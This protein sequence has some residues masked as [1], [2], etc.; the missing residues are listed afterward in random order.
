MM[1]SPV[2]D[3]PHPDSPTTPTHSPSPTSKETPSTATTAPVRV[4]NSVRRLSTWR[5]GGIGMTVPRWP[6]G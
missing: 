4:R 5:T 1:E 3:L 6:A 2:V